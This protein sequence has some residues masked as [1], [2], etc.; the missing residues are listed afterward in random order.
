MIA[1]CRAGQPKPD[2]PR[3][4]LG[5]G[6]GPA[7][8]YI[9]GARVMSAIAVWWIDDPGPRTRAFTGGPFSTRPR[10]SHP[11]VATSSRYYCRS[12]WSINQPRHWRGRYS[13][14]P[15]TSSSTTLGRERSAPSS[16]AGTGCRVRRSPSRCVWCLHGFHRG[17]TGLGR[18]HH[19]QWA[20]GGCLLAGM[21]AGA[22]VLATGQ[23]SACTL[24]CSHAEHAKISSAC[25]YV[26]VHVVTY[27]AAT[28]QA[29]SSALCSSVVQ[30]R[31]GGAGEVLLW[32]GERPLATSCMH[33]VPGCVGSPSHV[34]A[35]PIVSVA[36]SHQR[37]PSHPSPSCRH[38][39]P[40]W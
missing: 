25:P 12:S 3:L 24:S 7:E 39:S 17:R 18:K 15:C 40:P 4:L 20:Q 23:V 37:R 11:A 38:P 21:R 16:Y 29:V 28:L 31:C 36:A 1:R 32:S 14:T 10:G 13:S 8:S 5:G 26:S 33:T 9:A 34:L 22:C 2:L 19:A 35:C 30:V 6:C 27:A